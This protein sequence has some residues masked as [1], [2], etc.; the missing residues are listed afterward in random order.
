MIAYSPTK[1]E[2]QYLTLKIIITMRFELANLYFQLIRIQSKRQFSVD[3]LLHATKVV[4][5]PL[6]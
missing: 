1:F 6:V 3:F 4:V 2:M 5:L